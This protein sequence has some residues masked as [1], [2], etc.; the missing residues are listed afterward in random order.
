MTKKE[1]SE[2]IT[3][4]ANAHGFETEEGAGIMGFPEIQSEELNFIY[5]RK[6]SKDTDWEKGIYK[7]DLRIYASVC[8]MGGRPTPE[9]LL[10]TADEVKRG[11][12]LTAEL[13]SMNLSWIE[14]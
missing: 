9:E 10:K 4:T 2:I 8:K 1:L 6:T 14:A 5:M 11:A 12:E 13:Q 3:K 7:V